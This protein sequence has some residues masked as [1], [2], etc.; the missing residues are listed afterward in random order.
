MGLCPRF[1]VYLR[2]RPLPDRRGGRGDVDHDLGVG[3]QD[4]GLGG[5][6]EG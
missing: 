3:L 1:A 4:Q 5:S 6:V 2:A